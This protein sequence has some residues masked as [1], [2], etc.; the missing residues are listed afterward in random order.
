M[1]FAQ[2]VCLHDKLE[3]R[4]RTRTI[5][6]PIW[7]IHKFYT[8]AKIGDVWQASQEQLRNFIQNTLANKPIR[9]L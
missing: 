2:L 5:N 4:L 6:P 7:L 3:V 9:L 8:R 1:D